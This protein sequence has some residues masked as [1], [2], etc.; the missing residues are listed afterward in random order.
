MNT[1]IKEQKPMKIRDEPY[2]LN[3]RKEEQKGENGA[4]QARE[5]VEAILRREQEASK[6]LELLMNPH[7]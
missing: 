3:E 4:R 2:I 6:T 5:A 1:P 7:S